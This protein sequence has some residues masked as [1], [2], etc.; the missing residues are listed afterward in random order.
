MTTINCLISASKQL[1]LLVIS[2]LVL[3]SLSAHGQTTEDAD[4]LFK[5][6]Q[7]LQSQMAIQITGLERIQNE[8][9]VFTRGS[10]E[11]QIEQV[12]ASYNHIISRN[13]KGQIERI[14]IVNKKQKTEVERIVLPTTQL[15]N[16]FMVSVAI[17]GNGSNWQTV[18]MIIDTGADLVVLPESMIAQLG[19]ADSTFIR[20]KMQTANGVTEAK[21]GKLQEL[22]IAGESVENVEVAFIADQLLGKNC[23]LGMSVLGRYQ[24]NI[25]DKSQ[26]ITLFKK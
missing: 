4:D 12:L 26:L 15:G 7:S 20:K 9:K 19:L 2:S 18:D 17:S 23:L 6:I 22:R 3:I 8:E 21:I 10:L 24:I 13:S 25:D 14:V 11:Q 16:H 1:R 5:Q